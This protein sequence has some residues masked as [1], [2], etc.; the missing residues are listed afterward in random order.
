MFIV[1]IHFISLGNKLKL[2]RTSVSVYRI[3][4]QDIVPSLLI[5]SNV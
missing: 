2:L 4:D 3:D 1:R 5:N